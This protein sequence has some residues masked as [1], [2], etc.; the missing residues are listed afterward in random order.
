MRILSEVMLKLDVVRKFPMPKGAKVL[1]VNH[2][3]TS[4]PFVI[5]NISREHSII[6]VKEVLFDIPIFGKYLKWSG[7]IPVVEGEGKKAFE[8]AQ[9]FLRKGKTIIVFIEGEISLP[10]GEVFKPKTGAVR[11]ALSCK[12]PIVPVGVGVKKENIKLL[13]SKIKGEREL[14]TWYFWGPYAITIG[15]PMTL[16]GR[17]SDRTNVR[18]LSKK[19]MRKV[20]ALS[21][22][23]QERILVAG[24]GGSN[25][26][27]GNKFSIG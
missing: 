7:H 23:S 6:L 5:T 25:R 13:Y 11:L 16:V 27:N 12:V 17:V 18:A 21:H 15:R 8:R 19:L 14:G 26:F 4:D 3:T 20:I 9:K 22:E 2:P 1:V 10:D 24:T